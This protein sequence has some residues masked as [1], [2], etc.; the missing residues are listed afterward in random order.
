MASFLIILFLHQLQ[1]LLTDLPDF[2]DVL[3]FITEMDQ[4]FKSARMRIK[5]KKTT[6]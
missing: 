5:M 6:S 4:L 2:L 3:P 1:N